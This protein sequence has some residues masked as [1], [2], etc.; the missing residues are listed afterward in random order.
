MS[1]SRNRGR[2]ATLE[3]LDLFFL[4]LWAL[5]SPEIETFDVVVLAF[6]WAHG[7]DFGPGG[8]AS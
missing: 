1:H 2:G 3:K 4:A 6:G 7:R 8:C 5:S